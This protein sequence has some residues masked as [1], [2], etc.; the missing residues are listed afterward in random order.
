ME[1][2]KMVEEARK[3]IDWVDKLLARNIITIT[4]MEQYIWDPNW[5]K[6]VCERFEEHIKTLMKHNALAIEE[7]MNALNLLNNL[8]QDMYADMTQSILQL[9]T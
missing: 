1:I 5:K 7:K 9:K 4:E 3:I 6:D 2:E 8:E